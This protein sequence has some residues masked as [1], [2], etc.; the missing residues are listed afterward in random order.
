MPSYRAFLLDKQGKAIDAKIL[1]CKNDEHAVEMAKQYVDGCSV[2]VWKS[3]RDRSPQ[4]TRFI[5]SGSLAML[6]ERPSAG[7]V[8]KVARH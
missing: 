8:G 7:G 2:Q 6:G 1:D 3:E 5:I 4:G